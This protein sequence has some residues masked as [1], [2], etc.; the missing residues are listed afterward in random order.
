MSSRPLEMKDNEFLQLDPS[1]PFNTTHAL[2]EVAIM[3][4]KAGVLKVDGN[5]TH[6]RF[7]M[8]VKL[9]T[10]MIQK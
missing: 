10:E 6:K 2:E 4:Y 9:W 7:S 5:L 1:V 3:A 8:Q